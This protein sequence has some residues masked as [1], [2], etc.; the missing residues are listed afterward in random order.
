MAGPATSYWF[1]FNFRDDA[2]PLSL[3]TALDIE[4]VV[5]SSSGQ[6]GLYENKPPKF[7]VFPNPAD[8]E[9]TI[10]GLDYGSKFRIIDV[11]GRVVL[12]EVYQDQLPI[13]ISY[14]ESGIYLIESDG[15][16]QKIYV[17]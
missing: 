11:A 14:L 10:L 16:T 6:I 15:I 8:K 3:S 2:C 17:E 13:D 4:V 9:L 5:L 7:E 1:Q 12:Q